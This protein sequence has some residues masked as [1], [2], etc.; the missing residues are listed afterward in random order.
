[1]QYEYRLLVFFA[2]GSSTQRVAVM[3]SFV[4]QWVTNMLI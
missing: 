3:A 4:L 1:M 2:I